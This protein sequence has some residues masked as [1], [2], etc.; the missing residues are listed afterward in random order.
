MPETNV[1]AMCFACGQKNEAGLKLTFRREGDRLTTTFTPG[2]AYQGYPGVT[3]GGIIATVLDEVMAQVLFT[4]GI[5]AVTAKLEV[6]YRSA[7][8]TDRAAVFSGRLVKNGRRLYELEAEAKDP[9]G[10]VYASARAT[11]IPLPKEAQR[12]INDQR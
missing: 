3:H 11:Y 6:R 4:E 10:T 8:P 12:A 7:M 2:P 1:Y 5:A 9:S